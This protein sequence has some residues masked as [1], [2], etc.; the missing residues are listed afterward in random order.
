MKWIKIYIYALL[1]SIFKQL[2]LSSNKSTNSNLIKQ[3]NLIIGKNTYGIY[4]LKIDTYKGSI[5]KVT[6][7]N[8]CSISSGVKI[9]CGGIH[10]TNWISTFPFRVAFNLEG[11]F[12]DGMP[13]TK[14]DVIINND[15][16]IGTG[17]TILSG[18]KIGNGAVI[19]AKAVVTKDI[20][21]Y[22][23]VAGVPAKIIRYRFSEC[24]IL[25]LE[26]IKWWN[27]DKEKLIK[28]VDL[29]SSP[30]MKMFIEQHKQ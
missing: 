24:D 9:I 12:I 13:T 8:Y 14:G 23:I 15:V 16:W 2:Q 7:G 17:V 29:L 22:A 11:K 28:N 19:C 30:D 6:I 20:P 4:E 10:P 1:S 21:S 27:W 25:E 18:I 5:N 3:G 26:K